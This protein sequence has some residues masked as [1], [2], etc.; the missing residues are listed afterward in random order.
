MGPKSKHEIHLE[1]YICMRYE[2]WRYF[3]KAFLMHLGSACDLSGKVRKRV[4]YLWCHVSSQSSG[5]W[6]IWDYGCSN[7]LCVVSGNFLANRMQIFYFNWEKIRNQK[8]VI[9]LHKQLGIRME[10]FQRPCWL[11]PK[12][13]VTVQSKVR[14]NN[15]D[16]EK[17]AQGSGWAP[18]RTP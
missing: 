1:T 12:I 10:S 11:C 14:T 15:R 2:A 6:S 17:E 7:Y 18:F 13:N 5:F 3:Y 9:L 16:L 8:V 4:F